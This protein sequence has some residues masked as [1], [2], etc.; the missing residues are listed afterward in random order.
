MAKKI[1]FLNFWC[2]RGTPGVK[3]LNFFKNFDFSTYGTQTA[4]E[5]V[6]SRKKT[7][8]KIFGH[9]LGVPGVKKNFRIMQISDNLIQKG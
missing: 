3:K 9:F 5:G 7:K 8:I 2:P 1:I 6:G 4:R